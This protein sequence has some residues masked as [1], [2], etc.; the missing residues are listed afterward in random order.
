MENGNSRW[1]DFSITPVI[2]ADRVTGICVTGRD[3]TERKN[4]NESL[5]SM[6]QEI[7]KQ[8][9]QEQK[10][11]TRAIIKAQER[12]R[13][14]I[15]QELHDNVNQILAGT[16]LYLGMAGKDAKMKELVKYPIELI[17]KT[18]SEIRLLSSKNV[19]PL[20]NVNLKE[21]LQILLDNLDTSTAIKTVF[22]YQVT[23]KTI[24]DE[25]K[26]NIYRLIQEQ[27][28]NILKH[29]EAK[30]VSVSLKADDHIIHIIVTDDGKGF[31][32]KKKRK[33]IGISNMMNRIES[34]NGEAE[35]VSSPGKGCK[36][37]IKIPY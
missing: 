10:K 26:L 5:K 11:I 21:L 29:A 17:D 25:L 28:N 7:L 27:L 14:H 20:K 37:K 36:I 24:E 2:E 18:I 6:E 3:I 12:E 9:I 22:V 13:N 23:D 1:I 16:K 32:V 15:G 34:F 35:I 31:D 33:G 4:T 30:N 8:K 19:T